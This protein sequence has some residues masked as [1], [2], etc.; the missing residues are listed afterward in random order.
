MMCDNGDRQVPFSATNTL[1]GPTQ[2]FVHNSHQ[3]MPQSARISKIDQPSCCCSRGDYR[4]CSHMV[5][6]TTWTVHSHKWS[7]AHCS[8]RKREG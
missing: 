7:C 5:G 1:V 8:K 3:N 4:A 6:T 2:P